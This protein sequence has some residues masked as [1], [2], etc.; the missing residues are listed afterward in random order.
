MTHNKFGF[1]AVLGAVA[2]F[3]G[4]ANA[5]T[6]TEDFEGVTVPA[7]PAGWGTIGSAPT[8]AANGNPGNALNVAGGGTSYLVTPGVAF[9][10]SQ[11]FSGSFDFQVT[12][13]AFYSRTSFILGDIQDG[14]DGT[15]G[16]FLDVVLRVKTFGQR[17][18]VT[19][20]DGTEI[21]PANV[22]NNDREIDPNTWYTMAVDWTATSGTTGDL[23][24]TWGAAEFMNVTGYTF[25]EN[26]VAFGFGTTNKSGLFDNINITGSA[27]PE[28]ASLALVGLGSLLIAGRRRRA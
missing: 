11:D 9:D 21:I 15:A 18:S 23:S 25:T 3:V 2:M 1:L 28:P 14:L 8:T 27:I 26:D 16:E 10:A 24:L 20:G 6:I 4:T 7:L 5:A 19:D 17:A 13:T 12:D 22:G